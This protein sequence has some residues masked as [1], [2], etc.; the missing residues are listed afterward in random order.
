MN[1]SLNWDLPMDVLGEFDLD[2]FGDNGVEPP[3]WIPLYQPRLLPEAVQ[4]AQIWIIHS[5][6]SGWTSTYTLPF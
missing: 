5:T 2:D 3:H 4:G 1:S 6:Y